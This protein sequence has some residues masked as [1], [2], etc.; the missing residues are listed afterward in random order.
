M[1]AVS[2][3][4]SNSELAMQHA[5]FAHLFERRE[6]LVHLIHDLLN[7]GEDRRCGREV[8]VRASEPCVH[9]GEGFG[10]GGIHR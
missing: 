10:D 2:S 6:L 3:P 7:F 4:A 1:V 5:K 8:A 9:A